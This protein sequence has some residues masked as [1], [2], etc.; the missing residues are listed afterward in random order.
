[1]LLEDDAGK[2]RIRMMKYIGVGGIDLHRWLV[3]L[4][5]CERQSNKI[6]DAESLP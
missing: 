5:T 2:G 6:T 1:M 4:L 3:I